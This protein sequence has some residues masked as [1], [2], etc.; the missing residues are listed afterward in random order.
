MHGDSCGN[1]FLCI[2]AD[3]SY[4]GTVEVEKYGEANIN[5]FRIP[6]ALLMLSSVFFYFK[7]SFRF[8]VFMILKVVISQ[9]Y[10]IDLLIISGPYLMLTL[11]VL[12]RSHG[13][14]RVLM[15]LISSTLD[16]MRIVGKIIA[17][18]W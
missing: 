3:P 10:L 17:N 18:S 14:I 5:A 15:H 12:R 13:N 7:F 11:I 4:F 8:D 16:L 2:I 6:L 1:V 9:G